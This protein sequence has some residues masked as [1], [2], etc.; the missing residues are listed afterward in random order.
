MAYNIWRGDALEVP[1][2]STF[3]VGG[4][5]ATADWI[6]VTMNRKTVRYDLLGGDTLALAA[7]GLYA[8]LAAADIPEFQEVSWSYNEGDAFFLGTSQTPGV[9]FDFSTT[10]GGSTGTTTMVSTTTAASG[11][12]WYDLD[13]NWSLGHIPTNTENAVVSGGADLL[14]GAGTITGLTIE[15]RAGFD[16]NAGLPERN[17]LG[18]YEYRNRYITLDAATVL[19]GEGSGQGSSQLFFK[20]VASSTWTVYTTGQRATD[21][22]P[23]LDIDMTGNPTLIRVSGGDVGLCVFN[24]GTARTVATLGLSQSDSRVTI[25]RSVTVTAFDL[26][27][28]Q[29]DVWG[30]VTA[31][32]MGKGAYNQED[33]TL[34]AITSYGGNVKMNHT[35]TVT[36]AIFRGQGKDNAPPI[37]DCTANNLARTFTNSEFTGGAAFL[38][39]NQTVTMTNSAV[40]DSASYSASDPGPRFLFNRV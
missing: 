39:P 5:A 37:C 15:V 2:F 34:T 11:P 27:D 13:A 30:I 4:T 26:D 16:G 23:A 31:V 19:I 29:S 28:G 10:V 36:T 14:Y 8:L 18:F 32:T 25:G 38:D 7:A 9:P 33:G 20:A 22:L 3:T 21:S 24:E 17:A 6:A 12:N 1:Q 40:F 35:G